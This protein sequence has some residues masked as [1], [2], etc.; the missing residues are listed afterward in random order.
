MILRGSAC[1][2]V[3]LTALLAAC[4]PGH[5]PREAHAFRAPE[6]I[7]A[8]GL[9]P[10]Q[11]AQAIANMGVSTLSSTYDDAVG[12][13][14]KICTYNAGS[15]EVPQILGLEVRPAETVRD[16]ER[17]QEAGR[18]FLGTLSKGQVQD[19][20]GVGDA[21]LWAGGTVQQLHARKGAVNIVVT[22]Q[23]GKD[24]LAAAK[25]VAE[26]AFARMQEQVQSQ[27][28]AKPS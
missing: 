27:K 19:V 13:D 9:F 25:Q 7:E 16:A 6:K 23:A 22:I 10:F 17:R 21:A 26:R 11:E 18:S 5:D 14:T 24:P 28:P 8:C 3:I 1:G 20:A 15:V 4:G 12:R 2:A